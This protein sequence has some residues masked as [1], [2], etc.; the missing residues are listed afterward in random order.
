MLTAR[1][2]QDAEGVRDPLQEVEVL[3]CHALAKLRLK[4]TRCEE[5]NPLW[6]KWSIPE[7]GQEQVYSLSLL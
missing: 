4:P 5:H 7:P 1:F 2:A 6:G 3:F